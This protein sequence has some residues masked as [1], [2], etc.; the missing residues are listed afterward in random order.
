MD[1]GIHLSAETAVQA[2]RVVQFDKGA[3]VSVAWLL[4]AY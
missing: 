4:A 3:R 1:R 2:A